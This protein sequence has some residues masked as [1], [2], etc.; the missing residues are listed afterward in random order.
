MPEIIEGGDSSVLHAFMTDASQQGAQADDF[1]KFTTGWILGVP[2]I[3]DIDSDGKVEVVAM[4]RE[5]YLMVWDTPGTDTGNDE[6]WNG[7]HRRAETPPS[8][9]STPGPRGSSEG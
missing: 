5:G 6:W 9:A 1:P 3:G 8:T 7:R 4:T 2:A